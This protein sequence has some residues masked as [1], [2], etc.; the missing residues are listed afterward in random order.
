MYFPS[1]QARSV[2]FQQCVQHQQYVQHTH[3][4]AFTRSGDLMSRCTVLTTH[5][6]LDRISFDHT[7]NRAHSMYQCAYAFFMCHFGRI[8][9]FDSGFI[10]A[11]RLMYSKMTMNR[12]DFN[13]PHNAHIL[14]KASRKDLYKMASSSELSIP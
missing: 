9:L 7:K 14:C 8:A 11:E 12:S 1:V 5:F 13:R 4:S 3:S 2:Y 10:A 6:G